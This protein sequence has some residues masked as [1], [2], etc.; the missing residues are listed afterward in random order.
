MRNS[1]SGIK[2]A[3]RVRWSRAIIK[4][5]VALFCVGTAAFADAGQSCPPL[6]ISQVCQP[7]GKVELTIRQSA[8]APPDVRFLVSL[9]EENQPAQ[10]VATDRPLTLSLPNPDG[11]QITFAVVGLEKPEGKAADLSTCCL[12]N[13][14]VHLPAACPAP[15][16]DATLPATA[17][18]LAIELTLS[19]QCQRKEATAVCEGLVQITGPGP[20]VIPVTIGAEWGDRLRALGIDCRFAKGKALCFLPTG[21]PLPFDLSL[22]PKTPKGKA[23]LCADL[24][25]SP[26]AT[27]RTLALQRALDRA[28]Y[29]VGRVDGEFGPAT[30]DAFT[31]FAA[32][33]GL[34]PL[35]S[36][37]PAEVLLLLGISDFS[38]AVADNNR[39]CAAALVPAAPLQCDARSTRAAGDGCACRFKAMKRVSAT[40]C[41]CPKGQKL[42]PK[43]CI[44]SINTG[45]AQGEKRAVVQVMAGKTPLVIRKPL[46]C[47]M[48]FVNAV[49][50]RWNAK[51]QPSAHCQNPAF[52]PTARPNRLAANV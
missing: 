17:N 8:L 3:Q 13:Q 15:T 18:D 4:L 5:C 11:R 49:L 37:I 42:G 1:L 23:E 12:S 41:A 21:T 52:A 6:E 43:G 27:S 16:T 46:S 34:P 33:A 36:D 45:A 29:P 25:I 40:A 51:P 39:A 44:D 38:D 26:D 22:L 2:Y 30:L 28:G 7:N 35:Q 10:S 14:R 24:G 9:P 48:A 32:D 31:E 47:G 19:E 20:E 50:P